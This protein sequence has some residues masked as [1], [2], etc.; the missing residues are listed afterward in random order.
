MLKVGEVGKRR[1]I[2]DRRRQ[3]EINIAADVARL[4][5]RRLRQID[6]RRSIC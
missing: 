4:N 3:L 5:L 2:A 6:R 1:R